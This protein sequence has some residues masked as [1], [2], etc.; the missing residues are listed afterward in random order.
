MSRLTSPLCNL[1]YSLAIKSSI[2]SINDLSIITEIQIQFHAIQRIFQAFPII[3]CLR[4]Y[5]NISLQITC[6]K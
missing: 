2:L 5:M 1:R 3:D 4:K 6:M